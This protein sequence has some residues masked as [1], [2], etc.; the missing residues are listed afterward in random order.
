MCFS[1]GASF[2]ASGG[3]AITGGASLKLATKRQR[4]L[5][6]VPLLFAV[7]QALE[8]IQWLYVNDG[9]SS[10]FAAYAFLFF[11]FIVWPI[12]VPLALY[13]IHR[14]K[15]L[16]WFIGS[17]ICTA[18]IYLVGFLTN[19]LNVTTWGQSIDYGHTVPFPWIA[20]ILYAITILGTFVVQ[21]DH[22][23]L[24][25]GGMI[26]IAAAVTHIFFVATFASV[27]CFFAAIVSGL[28]YIYIWRSR[29]KNKIRK[30]RSRK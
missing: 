9:Q 5:A 11:G 30:N 7:Q 20:T 28:I 23:L 2:V 29:A 13:E 25:I 3:L 15:V 18:L 4:M 10:L 8:G 6:L 16:R 1:A 17:G 22:F 27:W 24:L 26:G 21:K 14:H 12:Y 19:P